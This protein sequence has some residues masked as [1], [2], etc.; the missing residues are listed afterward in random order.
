MNDNIIRVLLSFVHVRIE[1]P[2][3]V[4]QIALLEFLNDSRKLETKVCGVLRHTQFL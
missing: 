1:I 3:N 4:T 2:D